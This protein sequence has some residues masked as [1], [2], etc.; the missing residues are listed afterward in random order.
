MLRPNEMVSA[1]RAALERCPEVNFHDCSIELTVHDTLLVMTGEVRDII[2]KRVAHLAAIQV[3]G[4]DRVLD[5]LCVAP[6]ARHSD[7]EIAGFLERL[8]M[9]E[10]VFRDYPRQIV[11]GAPAQRPGTGNAPRDYAISASIRD[12]VVILEGTVGSLTHRRLVDVLA[13]WT[14]GVCGVRNFLHVVP[15]EQDTDAEITDALWI[16]LEKSL[17]LDAAAI[18]VR[19][20]SRKVT[21]EGVVASEEQRR[22]AEQGAWYVLGV[23][24]VDNR[25][26]VQVPQVP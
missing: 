9:Q 3:L 8:L 4:V 19:V 15:D 21:L 14:P 26:Q 7:V 23:H 18:V 10:S 11:A 16:I 1:V 20:K 5:E 6:T 13:W 25:L 12:A 2:A 17:S 22:M 24:G